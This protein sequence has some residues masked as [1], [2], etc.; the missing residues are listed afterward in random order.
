MIISK[1]AESPERQGRRRFCDVTVQEQYGEEKK[2]PGTQDFRMNCSGFQIPI[3]SISGFGRVEN[4][5]KAFVFIVKL[6][7]E[8]SNEFF[9]M[10]GEH[11]YPKLRQIDV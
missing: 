5:V 2:S 1:Q 9:F 3:F 4:V 6:T 8:D 10:R 11:Y 7:G